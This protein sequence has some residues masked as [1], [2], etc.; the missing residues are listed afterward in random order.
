M[1]GVVQKKRILVVDDSITVR[2]VERQLLETHGY[3]VDVAV[4]GIDGWNAVRTGQYDL[5]VSDIDMPRLDGIE[6]VRRIRADARLAALPVMIVSYKERPEDRL[7]G[8]DAGA[9]YYLAKASFQD[10][11]FLRAVEDLIGHPNDTG[12]RTS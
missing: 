10:E 1:P 6:F 7:R 4:D 12:G 5:V 9:S 3:L 2:E 8:L 11:T